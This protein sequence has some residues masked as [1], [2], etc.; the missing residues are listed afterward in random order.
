LNDA[1]CDTIGNS[2]VSAASAVSYFYRTV[3]NGRHSL[4]PAFYD[5]CFVG[6]QLA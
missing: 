4:C 1:V 6:R 3:N 5:V 2:H